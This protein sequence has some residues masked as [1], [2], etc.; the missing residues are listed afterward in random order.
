MRQAPHVTLSAAA[1]FYTPLMVLFAS[2]LLVVGAPGSAVGVMAGFAL[3][4]ALLVHVLVFGSDAA[5]MAA[6]PV[7]MRVL[8]AAGLVV[9]FVGAA[10]PG[11]PFAAQL[12]EAGA[13]LV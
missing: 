4:L 3:A 7:A 10:A 8:L 9:A 5:H 1:R 13:F 2:T 6:S 11:L 12:S